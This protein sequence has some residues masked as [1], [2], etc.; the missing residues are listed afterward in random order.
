MTLRTLRGPW[1]GLRAPDTQ[2]ILLPVWC[3]EKPCP[4]GRCAGVGRAAGPALWGW[5]HVWV[6]MHVCRCVWTSCVCDRVTCLYRLGPCHTP[7]SPLNWAPVPTP[8]LSP[9]PASA[10][11]SDCIPE[12]HLGGQVSGSASEPRACATRCVWGR[13]GSVWWALE[14]LGV[15]HPPIQPT[16]PS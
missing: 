1:P 2:L 3:P 16:W 15:L 14:I 10:L 6:A 4:V 8:S 5:P 7:T 12:G 9:R 13:G 11:C